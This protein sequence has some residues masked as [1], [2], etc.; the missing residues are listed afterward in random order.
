LDALE[1]YAESTYGSFHYLSLEAVNLHSPTLDHI[2]SHIGKATGIATVL[3]G[4]PLIA[5]SGS[6]AVVLPLDVCAEFNLRQEDVLRK[7]GNAQGLRDAVFKVATMA[8]DHLITARKMLRDAGKDAT[9]VAFATFLPAVCF[10]SHSMVVVG[11]MN[12]GFHEFIS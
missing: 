9:G 7:G 5:T 12:V 6:G 2:G 11:L 3:R 8:N 4:I 1:Q 10:L